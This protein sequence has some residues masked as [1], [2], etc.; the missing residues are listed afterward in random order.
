MK[1]CCCFCGKEIMDSQEYTLTVRKASEDDADSRLQILFCHE[2][3]LE[4]SLFKETLLYLK[5]L[6]QNIADYYTCYSY[7]RYFVTNSCD[8]GNLWN[9]ERKSYWKGEAAKYTSAAGELS[10]SGTYKITVDN[11]RRMS[12]GLA[13]IGT[14]GLSVQLHHLNGIANDFYNY[15]EILATEHRK[16]YSI[17]HSYLY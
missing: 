15:I 9:K 4:H 6:D 3:C 12:Q 7:A 1:K 2:S 5:F 14:D 17:L 10:R 8:Y 16:N 13:P 11:L